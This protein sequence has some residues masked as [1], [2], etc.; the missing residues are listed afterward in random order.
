M[1][2]EFE[3]QTELKCP[4]LALREFLLRPANLP[5]ISDPDLQLEIL[6]APAVISE[7]DEI[8]FRITAYGFKQRMR[9]RYVEVAEAQI[10]AEQI[11]GPARSWRHTQHMQAGDDLSICSLTDRV[12]FEPPGGMLGFVM[13]EARIR[14]S[15]RD[16]MDVRYETLRELLED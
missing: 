2:A 12:L 11:E 7:G 15:L 14:E 1:M 3:S 4:V 16:G 5:Q 13:T 8:E 10:I 9:H 6:N